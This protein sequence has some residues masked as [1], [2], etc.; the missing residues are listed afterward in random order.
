MTQISL[1]Y[2]I[3][4]GKNITPVLLPM[5]FLMSVDLNVVYLFQYSIS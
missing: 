5:G 2:L 3:F 4:S 1:K